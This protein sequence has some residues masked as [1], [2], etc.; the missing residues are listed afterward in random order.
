MHCLN[1]L[2][3]LIYPVYYNYS[4]NTVH[5][6]DLWYV[7]LNHCVDVLAQNLMCTGNTDLYTLNWMDTQGYPFPDFNINHQ[8]RDFD[9]LVGWRKNKGVDLDKWVAMKKPEGVRQVEPSEGI[10][11]LLRAEHRKAGKGDDWRSHG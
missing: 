9:A 8:R 5:H 6:A 11:E 3:K 7:H 4:I 1:Q 2:R 10:K